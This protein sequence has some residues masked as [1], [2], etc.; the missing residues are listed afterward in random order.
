MRRGFLHACQGFTCAVLYST[1]QL[2]WTTTDRPTHR[3]RYWPPSEA[4]GCCHWVLSVSQVP[5]R[6]DRL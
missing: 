3:Q 5:L 4:G 2:P 1:T 6:L